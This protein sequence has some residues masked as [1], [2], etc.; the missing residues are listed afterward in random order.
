MNTP[1]EARNS[2]LADVEK[3]VDGPSAYDVATHIGRMECGEQLKHLAIR[4]KARVHWPQTASAADDRRRVET[5]ELLVEL[6]ALCWRTA[7][8]LGIENAI[9]F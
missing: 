5:R 4:L 6:T 3:L 8:D 1:A 9:P 7:R 2:F